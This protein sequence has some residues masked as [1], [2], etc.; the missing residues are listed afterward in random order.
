[1]NLAAALPQYPE[2]S[3]DHDN[4]ISII[5][6]SEDVYASYIIIYITLVNLTLNS[7]E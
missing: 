7:A 3:L 2:M 5:L 1:M 4:H 6:S